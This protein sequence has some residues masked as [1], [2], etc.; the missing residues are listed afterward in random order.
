MNMVGGEVLPQVEEFKYLRV[1][2]TSEGRMDREIDRRIGAASAVMRSMYRSVVVKKELSRKAKLS[3]YQ[4]IYAPTL[5]YGHEL[6]VMTERDSMDLGQYIIL[7][8]CAVN[9]VVLGCPEQCQ[10][11]NTVTLCK[12]YEIQ[13]FPSPIPFSTSTLVILQTNITSLKPSDFEAFAESLTTLKLSASRIREVQPHT[14]EK[15]LHLISFILSETEL[16]SLPE[17][18]FVSL[19]DLKSLDLKKNL[20]TS[21]PPKAFQG[22]TQLENFTLQE[23][24][25]RNLHPGSF[26]GLPELKLLSLKQNKLEEIPSN[27]FEHLVNLESLHLQNNVIKHL[28]AELFTHQQ[29]LQKL[30]LSNNSLTYLPE[31][32]FMNL[33]NLQQISLY[34]NQLQTLSPKTFGPMPLL[35]EMWLYDNELTRLDENV[36]SNLT[37]I[38]LLVVSRNQ[39]SDISPGA[40]N[41]LIELKEISLQSNHLTSL[42]EGVFRGLPNLA[43]ISLR[44][45]QIHHLPGKLLHDLSNLQQLELQNNSLPNLSE[46][47]LRS[48]TNASNVVLSENPWRCDHRI[49][50]LRDWLLKFQDKDL[51]SPI[52]NGIGQ[53]MSSAWFPP[54]M[55]L[56]IQAKDFILWFIRPE[57]FVSH[58][59]KVLQVPSGK[60]Q[61]IKD[62]YVTRTGVTGAPPWS[63]AWGWG[64]QASAWWPS[65]CLRDSAGHS[66]KKQHR[67]TFL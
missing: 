45:N 39:I 44:N 60:L 32:I 38:K 18:L 35:Q 54:D 31:G 50:P 23:N 25:I 19:Q 61:K 56:A 14:F 7:F 17:N 1:L 30:Y 6:W 52:R 21:I 12:G 3:I 8:I 37:H 24:N 59:L 5:T 15:T 64:M 27:A 41:G 42:E 62:C 43:N 4:S 53:V 34:N 9:A 57:N 51:S 33:P 58:G 40:F 2:F 28:S 49:V 11:R 26:H 67:P 48:L 66:P 13:D 20:L 63:Q 55:T 29:K 46:E 47:L 36:F 10:C 22:L 16:S 65:L